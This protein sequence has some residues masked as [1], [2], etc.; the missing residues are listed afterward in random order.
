MF[1]NK[2]RKQIKK[3]NKSILKSLYRDIIVY[4]VPTKYDCP[5]CLF[6]VSTGESARRHDTTFIAPTVINGR[7]ITPTPFTRGRCTVCMGAGSI[8]FDNKKFIRA[9]TKW[10]P[11][12]E[13]EGKSTQLPIGIENSNVVVVKTDACYYEFIRDCLYAIIDGVKCEPTYTPEIRKLSLDELHVIA[14]FTS[15][16]SDNSTTTR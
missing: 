9:Y 10:N 13:T 5:N 16:E 12:V 4:G 3:V 15:S 8:E 2:I 6:D 1:T 11:T 14:Y 7:T